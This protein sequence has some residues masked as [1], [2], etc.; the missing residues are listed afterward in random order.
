MNIYNELKEAYGIHFQDLFSQLMK[1]KYGIKYQPICSYGN[2]GDRCV[3]GILNYNTAFAVYAPEIYKDNKT[4]EKLKS[5][6]YGFMKHKQN[7]DWEEIQK[8]IFVIKNKRIG[9][10]PEINKLV[11]KFRK[12]FP[13]DI[14]TLDDLQKMTSQYLPFSEDAQLLLEFKAD[15][16]DIM[17]YIIEIDFAAEPFY[18]SLPDK[19]NSIMEKWNRKQNSFHDKSIELIKNKI[20]NKLLNFV[21]I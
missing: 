9:I 2:I 8:Y 6:F 19:I 18:I 10:T 15:V 21:S 1:A 13:V 3:D 14:L 12:S 11:A 17:E 20:L 16:T 5:D 7:G 4:I